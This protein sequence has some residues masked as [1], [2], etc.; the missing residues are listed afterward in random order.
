M[1]VDKSKRVFL[2]L[3]DLSA[4]F[5]TVDHVTLLYFLRESVGLSGPAMDI[6]RSYPEGRT[7]RVSIRNVLSNL[8]ELIFGVPQ[9]S[10]LGP[11]IFCI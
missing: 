6:L 7:Q 9:G 1:A 11:L 3:L 5:A 4:T 10:V 2:V 8:G